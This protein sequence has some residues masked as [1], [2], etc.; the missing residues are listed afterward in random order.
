MI[1]Q[2]GLNIHEKITQ[3]EKQIADTRKKIL[4]L[5]QSVSGEDISDYMLSRGDGSQVSLD[6]LFGNKDELIIIHNMGKG[7]AYCT[8][9]ADG[10]N[11]I[12][13]HLENRAALAL[14]SPDRPDVMKE[15]TEG[16][17]WKFL[18]LSNNGG[19][20]T[21]DMGFE[22]ESGQPQPG[23]STFYRDE[24]GKIHR[25]AFTNFGPGDDFCAAW[26]IF[27]HLKNGVNNWQPKFNY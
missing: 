2:A 26:H 17:E 23:M 1:D 21:K 11:G 4:E 10:I 24:A 22:N 12:Y 18:C 9:W 3:L 20:F 8:L 13:H 25:T 16:R 19:N 5:R 6:E 7:C 14:I 27:D 15:F